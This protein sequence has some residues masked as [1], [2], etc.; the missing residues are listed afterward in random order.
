M[1]YWC[2]SLTVPAQTH[3]FVVH[4]N[5]DVLLLFFDAVYFLR[6]TEKAVVVHKQ[7]NTD[8]SRASKLIRTHAVAK[9]ART[10][11]PRR[12]APRR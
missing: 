8:V 3:R 11:A 5:S 1:Q 7:F 12:I 4:P 9:N 6:G 2:L 10:S